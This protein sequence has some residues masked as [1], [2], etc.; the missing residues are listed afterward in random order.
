MKRRGRRVGSGIELLGGCPK[1]GSKKGR[2]G[3]N[4]K[5]SR[6]A[7]GLEVR[8]EGQRRL[9]SYVTFWGVITGRVGSS[10]QPKKLGKTLENRPG[11]R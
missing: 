11:R 10:E 3:R 2:R 7:R 1:D 8:K 5:P 9:R 4:E 6:A